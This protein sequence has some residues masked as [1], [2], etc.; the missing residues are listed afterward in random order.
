MVWFELSGDD[1]DI[2]ILSRLPVGSQF[3]AQ[4][5]QR[6]N[7]RCVP[8]LS[9]AYHLGHQ[10]SQLWGH[11]LA[12]CIPCEDEIGGGKLKCNEAA[13]AALGTRC[14]DGFRAEADICH[15]PEQRERE[16]LRGAGWLIPEASTVLRH[17]LQDWYLD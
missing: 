4:W 10:A 2:S 6:V 8:V 16:N 3:S 15:H 9:W 7:L 13:V 11:K 17:W 5:M 1:H 14:W 12:W